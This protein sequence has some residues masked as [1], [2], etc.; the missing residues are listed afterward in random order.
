VR[1]VQVYREIQNRY[2]ESHQG[3]FH[4]WVILDDGVFALVERSNGNISVV[5]K[6]CIKFLDTPTINAEEDDWTNV[7]N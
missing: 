1:K 2:V 3:W 5:A 6:N 4:R 7:S